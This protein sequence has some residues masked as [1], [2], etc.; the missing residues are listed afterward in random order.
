MFVKRC[1][2]DKT[3]NLWITTN[4]IYSENQRRDIENFLNSEDGYRIET[5][6]YCEEILWRNTH[7]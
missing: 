2:N 6:K 1:Y 5:L 7:G 3:P 4:T